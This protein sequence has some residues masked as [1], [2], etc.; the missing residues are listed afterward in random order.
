MHRKATL[1]DHGPRLY[2]KDVI[3]SGSAQR[4]LPS[5]SIAVSASCSV[6][7]RARRRHAVPPRR[8]RLVFYGVS[9]RAS[10]CFPLGAG[11]LT[12]TS[13]SGLLSGGIAHRRAQTAQPSEL[14]AV[15]GEPWKQRAHQRSISTLP[16][17]P[18]CVLAL[19]VHSG[20]LSFAFH[21]SA[22]EEGGSQWQ[23]RSHRSRSF[24]LKTGLCPLHYPS[25]LPRSHSRVETS[26]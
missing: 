10:A 4:R 15:G 23:N 21:S 6:N 5:V 17:T 12:M 22:G 3:I 16:K 2:P 11:P 25:S 1:E 8:T 24:S 26:P 9:R 20:K 18:A 19:A 13:R 14:D 7:Q